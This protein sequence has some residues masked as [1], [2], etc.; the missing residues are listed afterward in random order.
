M[1]DLY[2]L[3]TKVY[4]MLGLRHGWECAVIKDGVWYCARSQSWYISQWVHLHRKPYL[5]IMWNISCRNM[6]NII[7]Y[8]QKVSCY[9]LI[10]MYVIVTWK[11]LVITWEYLA[12]YIKKHLFRTTNLH[13]FVRLIYLYISGMTAVNCCVFK[14]CVGL[15][16][17]KINGLL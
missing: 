11:Y 7:C 4:L 16:C 17:A 14:P 9:I 13:D 15:C 5:I 10:N 6:I 2:Y 3:I 8:Y 12:F 1:A